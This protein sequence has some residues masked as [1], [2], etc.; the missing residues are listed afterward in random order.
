MHQHVNGQIKKVPAIIN[1]EELR[2]EL[3][4]IM[5]DEFIELESFKNAQLFVKEIEKTRKTSTQFNHGG[6]MRSMTRRTAS[7]ARKSPESKRDLGSDPKMISDAD[8]DSD[9][10]KK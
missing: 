6:F 4:L 8:N 7:Q 5:I 10:R 1:L 9:W 2:K 3:T